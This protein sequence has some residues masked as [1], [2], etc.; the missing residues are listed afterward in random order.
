MVFGRQQTAKEPP[1]AVTDKVETVIGANVLVK[2]SF[3]SQGSLRID[4]IVEGTIEA[5]GNVIVGEGARVVAD[6]TAYHVSVAGQVKGNISA[7]GRLEITAKGRVWGD[8]VAASLAVDEGGV[9]S[10]R[11]QLKDAAL[12]PDLAEGIG[13]SSKAP[14]EAK[15]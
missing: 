14:V 12:P 2:G 3:V 7:S 11:S 6:I 9:L 4:G 8:I 1:P 5:K 13:Q 15:K 10:G